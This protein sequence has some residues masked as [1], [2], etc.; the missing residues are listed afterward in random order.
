M[1]PR[2]IDLVCERA[3]GRY[4][5]TVLLQKR[6]RELSGQQGSATDAH[7]IPLVNVDRDATAIEIA[8]SEIN[9]GQVSLAVGEEAAAIKFRLAEAERLAVEAS[10]KKEKDKDKK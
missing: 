7:G 2:D 10:K 4:M 1:G 3:G 6:A 8:M 9:Q 5:A